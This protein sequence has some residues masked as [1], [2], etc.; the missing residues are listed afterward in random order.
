MATTWKLRDYLHER[1]IKPA[2]LARKM[3]GKMSRTAVYGLVQAE[4]PK[5]VYLETLDAV[6][7]ALRELTGEDVKVG[8][9]L[10]YEADA[11]EAHDVDDESALWLGSKLTPMLEPWEWGPEG[12]PEGRPVEFVPGEGL[13][14]Y[15]D[16]TA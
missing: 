10:E 12:E 11:E 9:L 6:L 2:A 16:D 5:A 8:D 14:I 1:R 15:D 3:D 4:P 13:Y 7:P